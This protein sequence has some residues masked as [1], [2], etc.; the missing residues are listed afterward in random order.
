MFN[1][2]VILIDITMED[3]V[4]SN[5]VNLE[6]FMAD[7]DCSSSLELNSSSEELLID[8]VKSYPHLYDKSNPCYKDSGMKENSWKEISNVLNMLCKKF[9]NNILSIYTLML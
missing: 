5:S 4:Y 8:L 1:T 7:E 3:H 2:V 6:E 9:V